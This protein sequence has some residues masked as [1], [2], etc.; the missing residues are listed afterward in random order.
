MSL[1]DALLKAGAV[2]KKQKRKVERDLKKSRKKSQGDRERAHVVRKREKAQA[3]QEKERLK[4]ERLKA[5]KAREKGSAQEA[6]KLRVRHL[7]QAHGV[8]LKGGTGTRFYFPMMDGVTIGRLWTPW[9]IARSLRAGQ[10]AIAALVVPYDDE[11][12]YLVIPR[13]IALTI[14]ASA[15][16]QLVFFN[17]T[18]G[19]DEPFTDDL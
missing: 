13:D 3:R 16:E 9:T 19:G 2:D 4:A 18:N 10:S 1:R 11:V 5:R 17:E 12:T 15:P 8:H 6:A 7:I 14:R